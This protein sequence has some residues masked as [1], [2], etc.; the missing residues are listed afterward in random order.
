MKLNAS[1]GKV[2]V[3]MAF[4]NYGFSAAF[5]LKSGFAILNDKFEPVSEVEVGDPTK[6]Y[7]HDPENWK[8][9]EVL[10]YNLSAELD[11]PTEGG[12]YYVAFFLRNAQGVGAQL[13]NQV[14]FENNYNILYSFEA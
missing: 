5:N 12:K 8:S 1:D 9:T 13:S 3:D 14:Q 2:K 10:D 11:A 7:S 4:K 6:W